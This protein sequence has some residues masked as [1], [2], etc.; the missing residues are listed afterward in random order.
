MKYI[1]TLIFAII[2]TISFALGFVDPDAPKEDPEFDK[3]ISRGA[4]TKIELHVVDDEGDP[5]P[6]ANVKVTLGMVTT[7]NI[8]NGQT[9]TNGVFIIEGKTRGNEIIIQPKKDGYY[10]SKKTIIYWG[11]VFCKIKCT[12]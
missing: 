5:V 7:A 10:N 11:N 8:I 1:F 9:D 12:I 3:V 6:A 2:T 4:K